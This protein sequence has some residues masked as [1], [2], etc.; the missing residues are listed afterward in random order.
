MFSQVKEGEVIKRF[1][2]RANTPR[3][4]AAA[5]QRLETCW[6]AGGFEK[7]VVK[8]AHVFLKKFAWSLFHL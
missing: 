7:K 6:R 5:E 3:A 2:A 4:A 1:W 8:E